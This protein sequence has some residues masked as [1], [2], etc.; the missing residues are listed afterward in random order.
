MKN[1]EELYNFYAMLDRMQ[2]IQRWGLMRNTRQ[3]NLK[4]HSFDVAVIAHSLALIHNN[5]LKKDPV[6]PFLTMAEALYHDVTEIITGD[7]PTPIKYKNDELKSAY[8]EVEAQAARNL[9]ALL[10]EELKGDFTDLLTPDLS[11]EKRKEVHRLVKVADRIS[12]FL[13]CLM[14][15]KAANDEF[16]SAKESIEKSIHDLNCEEAEYYLAHFVPPYGMTLDE[17]SK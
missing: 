7:M 12:A 10:P 14:E 1:K 11:D 16:R 13:K 8:K 17:I 3:E 15:E 5:I 9:L 4:E 2:Y 6:D